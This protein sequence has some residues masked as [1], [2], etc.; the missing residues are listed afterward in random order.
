MLTLRKRWIIGPVVVLLAFLVVW[1]VANP[2]KLFGPKI[3]ARLTRELARVAPVA[4]LGDTLEV[5]LRG[6]VTVGP[7]DLALDEHPT[8]RVHIER[9]VLGAR[10]WSLLSDAPELA[11]AEADDVTV[12]LGDDIDAARD[13]VDRYR[14]WRAAR[15]KREESAKKDKS[16]P[17]ARI[18]NLRIRVPLKAGW[19]NGDEGWLVVRGV[20]ASVDC[21]PD[22]TVTARA[23]FPSGGSVDGTFAVATR[24]MRL[25]ADA[26]AVNDMPGVVLR[27]LPIR[28]TEGALSGTLSLDVAAETITLD[29]E[30]KARD[31]TFENDHIADAPVRFVSA[32]AYASIVWSRIEN[33]LI[34][35]RSGMTI[36]DDAAARVTLS[37]SID[38]TAPHQMSW[39]ARAEHVPCDPLIAGLP[40]ALRPADGDPRPRGEIDAWFTL[41]GPA[42]DAEHWQFAGD[43]RA[44]PATDSAPTG[45]EFLRGTFTHRAVDDDG[46]EHAVVIGPSSASYVPIAGLPAHVVRAVTTAEDGGFYG[47]H[48]FD[49]LEIQRS[50]AKDLATGK[51]ARGGS[52]ITQQLAKNLFL[53]SEKT[54]S[55]KVRE[56]F[57]ALALESTLTKQRMLEIYL[58][59]IEWGPNVYGLGPAAQRYFGKSPSALTPKEAA[60]LATI[61]PNPV[62]YYTYYARGELTETWN[63]RVNNILDKLH[64]SGILDD[65][66]HALAVGSPVV[67]QTF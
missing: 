21:R 26:V 47:H 43:I 30:G 46:V 11:Y 18:E 59:A 63:E 31:L 36:G 27:R 28:M 45:A 16:Y 53:T 2:A 57:I 15:P 1:W 17:E 34:I 54:Y 5:S 61:I 35:K 66:A 12:D 67:F 22:C 49:L 33:R 10:V 37:G 7:I 3:K 14:E 48:G 64:T 19:Q 60:Y 4:T 38:A 41:S 20:D 65:E 44:S 56:A 24:A 50:I 42:A 6:R 40:E 23:E 52:T 55:R 32:G 39:E 8:P 29:V 9:L 62:R 13:A 51:R 58:N 25:T